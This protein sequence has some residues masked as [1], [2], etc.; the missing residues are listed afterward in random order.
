MLLYSLSAFANFPGP[1]G[2]CI[3]YF[4]W[5]NIN[6]REQSEAFPKDC[7]GTS[8]QRTSFYKYTPCIFCSHS[9][10]NV[11]TLFPPLL[12]GDYATNLNTNTQSLWMYTIDTLSYLQS[13]THMKMKWNEKFSKQSETQPVFLTLQTPQPKATHRKQHLGDKKMRSCRSGLQIS[14]KV[15]HISAGWWWDGHSSVPEQPS[16]TDDLNTSP[17]FTSFQSQAFRLL[18]EPWCSYTLSV[19]TTTKKLLSWTSASIIQKKPFTWVL[20]KWCRVTH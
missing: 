2:V 13:N 9:C 7:K 16:S 8:G 17:W 14:Q 4:I 10:N 12:N 20:L 19:N 18:R 6:F 1:R 11:Y 3:I 5:S 15:H